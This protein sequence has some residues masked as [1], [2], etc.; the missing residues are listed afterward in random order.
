MSII[1]RVRKSIEKKTVR[2]LWVAS[3]GRCEYDG[4]NISL[5]EDSLTKKGINIMSAGFSLRKVN[6]QFLVDREHFEPAIISLNEVL[7]S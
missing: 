6:I 5:L 4:C 2:R 1:K 7:Y 3:G